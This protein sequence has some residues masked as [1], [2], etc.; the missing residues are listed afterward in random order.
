MLNNITDDVLEAFA[1]LN[2]QP[3]YKK[4]IDFYKE[5]LAELDRFNRRTEGEALYRGQGAAQMLDEIIEVS[6]NSRAILNRKR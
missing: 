4:I 2:S 6:Q 3:Q 5:K 1:N